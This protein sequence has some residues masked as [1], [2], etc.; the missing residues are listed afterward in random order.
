MNS[1]A[2]AHPLW[3]TASFEDTGDSLPM[4]LR[5]LGRHTEGCRGG[6][7]FA[8]HSSAE[9]IHRFVASRFVTTLVALTL[10]IGA[11]LLVL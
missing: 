6:R 10:L 3:S 7:W 11:A 2:I 4:E 9:R 8:L 1:K 5:A